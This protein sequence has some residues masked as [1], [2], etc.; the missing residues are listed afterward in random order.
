MKKLLKMF[1][2]NLLVSVKMKNQIFSSLLSKMVLFV[3]L[4]KQA[5]LRQALSQMAADLLF[6]LPGILLQEFHLLLPRYIANYHA[7]IFIV[8]TYHFLPILL[9]KVLVTG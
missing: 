3:L 1:P 7:H 4:Y 8:F 2:V 5:H 9:Q 6:S